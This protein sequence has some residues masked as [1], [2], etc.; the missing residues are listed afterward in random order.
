[1]LVAVFDTVSPT[2]GWEQ[3]P[4]AGPGAG[5]SWGPSHRG[6]HFGLGMTFSLDGNYWMDGVDVPL[7]G[8]CRTPLGLLEEGG[9]N[10]TLFFT[11]RFA[12]C[13][14]QQL[15]PGSRGDACNARTMCA[16]VYAATFSVSWEPWL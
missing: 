15:P 14:D 10:Y 4:P 11:R 3:R 6:E 8:G 5:W 9:G 1:M 7:P 2:G 12:D 13:A 16:N